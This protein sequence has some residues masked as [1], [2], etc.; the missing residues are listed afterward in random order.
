MNLGKK[1][2]I[3]RKIY[4]SAYHKIKTEGTDL[5]LNSSELLKTRGELKGE[6][7]AYYESTEEY[8]KCKFINNFFVEL[9]KNLSLMDLLTD[10]KAKNRSDI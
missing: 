9:E 10:L 3:I 6:L 1:E 7:I 8:E 5:I 4:E 2:A